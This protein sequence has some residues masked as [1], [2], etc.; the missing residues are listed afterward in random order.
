MADVEYDI[1]DRFDRGR[2]MRGMMEIMDFRQQI[3]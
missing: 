3:L 1:H 2:S